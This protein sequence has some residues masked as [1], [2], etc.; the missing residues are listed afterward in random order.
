MYVI[1]NEKNKNRA[2]LCS[3]IMLMDIVVPHS[4]HLYYYFFSQISM[5]MSSKLLTVWNHSSN[6]VRPPLFWWQSD[7]IFDLEHPPIKKVLVLWNAIT[8]YE[9]YWI[10]YVTPG[11][12]LVVYVFWQ[13]FI[14]EMDFL[15]EIAKEVFQ[16]A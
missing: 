5:Q 6:F 8:S 9:Y 7:F 13:E 14:L 4:I 2:Q 16:L 15:E 10:R 12:W 1:N 3:S 11:L